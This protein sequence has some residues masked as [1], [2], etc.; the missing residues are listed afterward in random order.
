MVSQTVEVTDGGTVEECDVQ[1]TWTY[2]GD[3]VA[4]VEGDTISGFVGL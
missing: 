4:K 1:E 2:Y 3:T